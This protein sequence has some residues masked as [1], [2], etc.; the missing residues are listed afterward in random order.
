MSSSIYSHSGILVIGAVHVD[1]IAYAQTPLIMKASNPIHWAHA[2]G[3]V[4][5][6]VALAAIDCLRGKTSVKLI[7]AIGSDAHGSQLESRL[8]SKGI[9]TQLQI[10]ASEK[11][12]RYSA[13]MDA[14]GE[15][16]LG[17][18]DVSIAERLD[19]KHLVANIPWAQIKALL[20]DCNLSESCMAALTH[21][22]NLCAVPVAAMAVSPHKA[23]R[24][25]G[26]ASKLQLLFCNR[27]EAIALCETH[28]DLAKYVD[29]TCS[30]NQLADNLSTLGFAQFILTDGK[31]PVIVHTASTRQTL[32]VAQLQAPASNVNGAGDAMAGAT[33]A[34]WA[35][36]MDLKDALSKFGLPMAAEVVQGRRAPPEL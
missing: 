26:I 21:Q 31:Q 5:A 36:G 3:G 30:I 23:R 29:D 27:R 24:L 28:P 7:G 19:A 2:T 18:S 22:S 1:E 12:G 17:L 10:F 20:L 13:I 8:R 4:A 11:T 25:L 14:D 34:Q 6:N 9:D 15:L 35:Y 32:P 33:F 16:A